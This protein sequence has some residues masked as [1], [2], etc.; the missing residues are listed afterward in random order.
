MI[1]I[2]TASPLMTVQDLGRPDFY[3]YG[4]SR[5]GAM[6]RL[7]LAAGNILL[8]NE[9]GAA[10]LEIPLPPV[11]FRFLADGAFALTGADCR[12]ILGGRPVPPW[13]VMPARAGQVLQLSTPSAGSRAYLSLPGGINVPEVLGSRSTQLREEF[14]GFD[15]RPVT[16]GDILPAAGTGVQLPVSGFGAV[17]ADAAIALEE[18]PGIAVR[19]IPAA[20]YDSFTPGSREA[21]WQARWDVTVQS[22]RAG[23]RLAGPELKL[24]S[25]LEL[26]SHGIVPGVVQVPTGGQPII[27]LADAATMGGYPKIATVIEADLWR[28]GQAK[29]GDTV[30]FIRTGYEEALASLDETRAYLDTLR[31]QAADL[32]TVT[33]AWAQP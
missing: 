26:R 12:A 17:P 6:D 3:R 28:I 33:K 31:Q 19:A 13:W 27:Q 24:Q 32:L 29:A 1:E 20:E 7:A 2:L 25:A 23:F 18:G 5:S 15:G 4:V 14:G 9:A 22:N 11:S 21:F 8:G 10:S 30:K 16:R